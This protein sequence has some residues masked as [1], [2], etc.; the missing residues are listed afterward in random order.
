[1][2]LWKLPQ[3][4]RFYFSKKQFDKAREV[5]NTIAKFN[6]TNH[7]WYVVFQCETNNEG[8]DL[9]LETKKDRETPKLTIN[10]MKDTL[11]ITQDLSIEH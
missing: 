3:S 8:T 7:K 9:I 11:D 10:Q 5:I 4:P 1:M 2:T 6:G